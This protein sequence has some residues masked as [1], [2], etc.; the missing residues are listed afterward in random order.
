MGT[1]KSRGNRIL[2]A[3]P[4]FILGHHR[5]PYVRYWE[6]HDPPNHR[7]AHAAVDTEQKNGQARKGQEQVDRGLECFS[8]SWKVHLIHAIGKKK[9]ALAHTSLGYVMLAE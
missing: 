9:R 6:E 7:D 1:C 5:D 8:C 2:F 4:Q 3:Q